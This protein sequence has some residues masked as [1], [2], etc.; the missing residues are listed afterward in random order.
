M[1]NKN[2]FFAFIPQELKDPDHPDSRLPL[3]IMFM[4]HKLVNGGLISGT[5]LYEPTNLRVETSDHAKAVYRNIYDGQ[6][7]IEIIYYKKKIE[8]EGTKYVKGEETSTSF[9]RD[10]KNFFLHLTMVGLSNGEGCEFK[11]I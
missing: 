5:S 3:N 7:W 2:T 1:E 9:G 8:W 6:C 11:K 10:W 4:S